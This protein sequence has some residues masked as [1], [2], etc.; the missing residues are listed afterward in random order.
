MTSLYE[1]YLE[2]WLNRLTPGTVLPAFEVAMRLWSL[3]TLFVWFDIVSNVSADDLVPY[4]AAI[5]SL[6]AELLHSFTSDEPVAPA[7]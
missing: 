7:R 4:S 6:L 1:A 5:P 3:P 2:P